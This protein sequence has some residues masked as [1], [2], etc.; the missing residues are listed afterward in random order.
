MDAAE[1]KKMAEKIQAEIEALEI[2]QEETERRI[3]RLKQALIGLA[4]LSEDPGISRPSFFG[5]DPATFLTEIDAMSITDAVRQ[6]L[7]AATEPLAPTE[8]K[9]KLISMG[10][11]IS[12]QKNVMASIH[13]LLKRL[14]GSGEIETEDNGLTYRWTARRR[15]FHRRR[16][17]T[18]PAPSAAPPDAE[19]RPLTPPPGFRKKTG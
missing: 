18:P 6:I 11:D 17:T 16:S 1:Y 19:L 4:P 3:A 14:H 10:K 9:Q 7:Q 2:Q 15:H 12:G 8:I 5:I 13:S